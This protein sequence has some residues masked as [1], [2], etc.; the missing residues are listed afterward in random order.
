MRLFSLTWDQISKPGSKSD[1]ASGCAKIR[2]QVFIFQAFAM[3]PVAELTEAIS[4][5]TRQ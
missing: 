3:A 1:Q 4:H 5:Q 2:F